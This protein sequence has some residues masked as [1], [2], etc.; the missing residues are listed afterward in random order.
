LRARRRYRLCHLDVRVVVQRCLERRKVVRR[1][2]IGGRTRHARGVDDRNRGRAGG[3]QRERRRGRSRRA[4]WAPAQRAGGALR[5][6]APVGTVPS[7]QGKLDV[8]SPWFETNARPDGVGSVTTTAP[9]FDG[10]LFLT[11][12][13]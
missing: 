13:V 7:A 6:V 1:S 2:G 5:S 11:V 10:P 3:R 4:G 12:I 9:A 8:Q